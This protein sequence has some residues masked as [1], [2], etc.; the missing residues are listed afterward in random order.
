MYAN[1]T[2][3]TGSPKLPLIPLKGLCMKGC[4]IGGEAFMSEI[5]SPMI[6]NN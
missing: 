1:S 3:P 5:T 2:S 6:Q 4:M